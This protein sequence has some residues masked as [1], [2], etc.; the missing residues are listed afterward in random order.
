MGLLPKCWTFTDWY[1]PLMGEIML[2]LGL[3]FSWPIVQEKVITSSL[4]HR[5]RN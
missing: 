5:Y 3:T 1:Q 2:L 4:R